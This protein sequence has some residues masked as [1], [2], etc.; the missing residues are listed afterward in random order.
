MPG[1]PHPRPLPSQGRGRGAALTPDTLALELVEEAVQDLVRDRRGI[2]RAF[3]AADDEHDQRNAR[4]VVGRK[5]AEP[6]VPLLVLAGLRID[7][8]ELGGAGLRADDRIA[9]GNLPGG[10]AVVER[11]ATHALAHHIDVL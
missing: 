3:V 4:V 5:G 8:A 2:L 6:G 7:L 1:G 11:V 10:G 9:E